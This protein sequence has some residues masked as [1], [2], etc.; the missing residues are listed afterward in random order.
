M[1]E[2]LGD[3]TQVQRNGNLHRRPGRGGVGSRNRID[4]GRRQ[5]HLRRQASTRAH[6]YRSLDGAQ[7]NGRPGLRMEQARK[8][9]THKW[10]C[11]ACLMEARPPQPRTLRGTRRTADDTSLHPFRQCDNVARLRGVYEESYHAK[12]H[13]GRSGVQFHSLGG[14]EAA[15]K[16]DQEEPKSKGRDVRLV[17]K[18][19]EKTVG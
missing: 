11:R 19:G 7:G 3:R 18:R 14:D 1:G 4:L 17:V 9:R 5:H 6:I 13:I 10:T 2:P 12:R 8:G 15:K 16:E